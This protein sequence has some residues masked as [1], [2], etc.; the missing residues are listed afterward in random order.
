MALFA[1]SPALCGHR[2]CGRG[3][4]ENTL[5]SCLAAVE[6]GATW[7]EVDARVSP[8]G[9]VVLSHEPISDAGGLLSLDELLTALPPAIGVDVE[10]K[11]G[12]LEAAEIA[13]R[14]ARGGRPV[15]VTSFDPEHLHSVR[16]AHPDL[17]LGLVCGATVPAGEAVRRA[18]ALG[19]EVVAPHVDAFVPGGEAAP[20]TAAHRAGL[21]VV[22]WC[23]DS[24][25]QARL[26]GAGVDCVIVDDVP[27]RSS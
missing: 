10:V 6:H 14:A 25:Q 4:G 12:P 2:G 1:G 15:V 21:E 18:V 13:A 24:E 20:I 7:L 9:V 3:P 8:D 11:D 5:A 26:A 23:P 17:P 19:V 16:A 22:A 27:G